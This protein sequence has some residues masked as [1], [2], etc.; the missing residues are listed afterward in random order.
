MDEISQRRSWAWLWTP[1]AI[2][3]MAPLAILFAVA[4]YLV[5]VGSLFRQIF[6]GLLR[7]NAVPDKTLAYQP[8]HRFEEK[9]VNEL[10]H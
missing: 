4:F 9:T 3:V 8:P 2:L 5:A 1:L 10:N 6:A 7:F